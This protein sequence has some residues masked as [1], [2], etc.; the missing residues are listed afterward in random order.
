MT[1]RAKVRLGPKGMTGR[2]E[3]V[4]QF[5]GTKGQGAERQETGQET[6]LQR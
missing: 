5:R 4:T 1:L 6:G 3:G 2:Q